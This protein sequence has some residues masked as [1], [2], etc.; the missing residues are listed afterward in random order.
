MGKRVLCLASVMLLGC[1]GSITGAGDGNAERGSVDSGPVDST[2]VIHDLPLFD[3]PAHP[4]DPCG[5]GKCAGEML[6]L[7]GFCHAI[8]STECGDHAPECGADEACH[9]ITSFSSA[10]L[11]GEAGYLESCGGGSGRIC[12]PGHLCVRWAG[13]PAK[14]LKLCKYGCP[15]GVPCGDTDNGCSVCVE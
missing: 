14:C 8:C 9:V 5:W 7:A 10:C 6:C 1:S 4:G 3:L 15:S 12:L 13:N 11:P 2:P